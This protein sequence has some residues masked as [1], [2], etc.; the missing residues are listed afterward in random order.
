MG[1]VQTV[2]DGGLP[3]RDVYLPHGLFPEVIRPLLAFLV[4]G[5][6][7]AADRLMGLLI[8][9]LAYVAAAYYVWGVFPTL[10]WRVTALIGCALYPLL[11][12]PRHIVVFLALGLL[13]SW[14]KDQT[15]WKLFGAGCIAGLGFV[16]STV[17]QAVFLLV[18]LLLVPFAMVVEHV[19]LRRGGVANES[20]N[21]TSKWAVG[22]EVAGP[23]W[24]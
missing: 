24:A 2:L 11:L 21:A 12:L 16:G 9:P 5:E 8:Q 13:T 19:A 14:A 20:C 15:R 3:I 6:S 22:V 10:F 18:T 23:L 1:V 17:D 4:F 7:L